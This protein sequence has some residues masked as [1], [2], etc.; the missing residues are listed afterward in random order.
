M[1]CLEL[2]FRGSCQ[3]SPSTSEVFNFAEYLAAPSPVSDAAQMR[4][5]RCGKEQLGGRFHFF[6]RLPDKWHR[7]QRPLPVPAE[8]SA[9]RKLYFRE[10][11][12]QCAAH[13][14]PYSWSSLEG[15]VLHCLV[16][17]SFGK[18]VLQILYKRKE[19]KFAFSSAFALPN[20][21][22]KR[23]ICRSPA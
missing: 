17:I 21:P 23:F 20:E 9:T 8:R 3:L 4:G 1:G 2:T 16:C 10:Q 18:L 7:V 15:L 22:S 12:R 19:R 5:R 6:F 14:R 13:E 11:A